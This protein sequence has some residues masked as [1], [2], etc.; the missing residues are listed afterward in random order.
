MKQSLK[1]VEALFAYNPLRQRRIDAIRKSYPKFSDTHQHEIHADVPVI[2]KMEHHFEGLSGDDV[3][4]ELAKNAAQIRSSR[5]KVT[6]FTSQDEKV[7]REMMQNTA[8][9]SQARKR[10]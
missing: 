10:G 1:A 4:A 7:I 6:H 5:G 3:I 8:A 2:P 9:L